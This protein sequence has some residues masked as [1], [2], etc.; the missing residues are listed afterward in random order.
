MPRLSR[1]F[2]RVET[3]S[4][5]K[6]QNC[7]EIC[8][9]FTNPI[10]CEII[11]KK[12][13]EAEL[14][15]LSSFL[16]PKN[17]RCTLMQIDAH[18]R[19][20]AYIREYFRIFAHI[21]HC[22]HHSTFAATAWPSLVGAVTGLYNCKNLLSVAEKEQPAYQQQ[23]QSCN[24]FS[25]LKIQF[26]S[27]NSEE[28]N[29]EHRWIATFKMKMQFLVENRS[30]GNDSAQDIGRIATPR[31]FMHGV[32]SCGTGYRNNSLDVFFWE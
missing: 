13:Q 7:N 21:A 2:I 8:I 23:I 3:G 25:L 30:I 1:D 29:D 31:S 22:P 14:F 27:G 9:F 11:K 10:L 16:C 26:F 12:V 32:I 17:C 6:Y 24:I 19:I 5:R 4:T 20:S 15:L 18:I 28:G